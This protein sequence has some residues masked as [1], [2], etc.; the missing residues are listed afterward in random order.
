MMIRKMM[1]EKRMP[2]ETWLEWHIRT[3]RV[4]RDVAIQNRIE[5]EHTLADKRQTWAGH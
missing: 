4:A 1:K 2:P 3:L 5:V